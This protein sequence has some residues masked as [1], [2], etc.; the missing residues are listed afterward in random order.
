M[1]KIEINGYRRIS[2]RAAAKAFANDIT[3]RVVPCKY[4]PDNA[5][6]TC[7][8]NRLEWER[9]NMPPGKRVLADW[10]FNNFCIRWS[11]YNGNYETGYYPAFYIRVNA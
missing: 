5:W 11:Y 6:I 7:D 1:N 4:R 3:V 2:K 8:L 9:A 10:C